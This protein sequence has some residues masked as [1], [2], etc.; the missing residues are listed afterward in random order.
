[1]KLRTKA[2]LEAL[3]DRTYPLL[4]AATWFGFPVISTVP[5]ALGLPSRLVSVPYRVAVVAGSIAWVAVA[6]LLH[7][8]LIDRRIR[9][10]ICILALMLLLRMFWDL[11]MVPLPIDLKWDD[12]FM[13][14]V[15]NALLPV[16]PFVF[17]VDRVPI[18]RAHRFC[19]W[20]GLLA[21]IAIAVG[22]YLSIRAFV[23][24]RLETDILN[25]ITIGATG[26]TL[27]I[28]ASSLT[29]PRK[30]LIFIARAVGA[31]AGIALCL[32]SASK[33]SLLGLLAAIVLQF[34]IPGH[35]LSRSQKAVR[36][37]AFLVL[38]TLATGAVL[39]LSGSAGFALYNRLENVSSDPGVAARW[40]LWR[41]A[42]EQFD[43]SPLLGDSFVQATLRFYPH[44]A[45]IE[46][47]LTTGV[48]G[49]ALLAIVLLVGSVSAFRTLRDP[50]LRWLGLIFVQQVLS[51]QTS[52][53]LY[54]NQAFWA[55]LLIVIAADVRAHY[56]ARRARSGPPG[57]SALVQAHD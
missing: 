50:G 13:Q 11:T 33:G 35:P 14:I 16:L 49:L 4:V 22:A 51:A 28:V 29:A 7:R 8:P 21:A 53:S 27:Y 46:A 54:F 31:L 55:A 57:S 18:M 23:G 30:V 9:W 56:L 2:A 12:L 10:C 19:L 24:G 38:V 1:V 45:F 17:V 32:L 43:R 44:N 20:V 37:T 52:G 42:V 39:W 40:L 36:I 6:A 26:V 34:A 3:L 25:P 15:G 41:G 47:M 48:I 5:V